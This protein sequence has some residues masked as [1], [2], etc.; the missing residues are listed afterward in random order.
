MRARLFPKQFDNNY[1]GFWLALWLFVPIVVGRSIQGVESIINTR[2]VIT[3]ADGIPLDSFNAAAAQ[4]VVSMFA[5]LGLQLLV[6][7]LQSLVVL[8]RYRAMIPFMFLV[9]LLV[10]IGSRALIALNPIVRSEGTPVGFYV[11]LVI[12][13]AT[14]IGFALSLQSRSTPSA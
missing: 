12:L 10:Q 6:I 5:L 4:T 2:N 1:S 11:N 9:L 7:P 13:M 14:L 3:G 8:V